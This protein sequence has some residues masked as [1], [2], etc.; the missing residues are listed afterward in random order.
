M[1]VKSF[2]LIK[3][4][5]FRGH[6]ALMWESPPIRRRASDSDES[7]SVDSKEIPTF[8]FAS[9]SRKALCDIHPSIGPLP[10]AIH[11]KLILKA[12]GGILPPTMPSNGSAQAPGD[13]KTLRLARLEQ[14]WCT[15]YLRLEPQRPTVSHI[16][17]MKVANLDRQVP[18]LK[19]M[20]YVHPRLIQG[21]T[22]ILMDCPLNDEMTSLFKK[23][24]VKK[25]HH[26]APLAF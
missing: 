13:V 6:R 25:L 8:N 10:A 4:I 11:R 24:Q 20:R 16:Q 9:R 26:V 19:Q 12:R 15:G 17:R 1:H 2:F 14:K 3:G 23:I 7:D 18:S 22:E 21:E 5:F